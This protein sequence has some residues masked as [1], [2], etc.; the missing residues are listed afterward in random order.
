MIAGARGRAPRWLAVRCLLLWATAFVLAPDARSQDAATL[1]ARE[2]SLRDRLAHNAFRLPLVLESTDADGLLEGNIHAVVAQPFAAVAR[3]LQAA[4][5][6][7]DILIV[8]PNVKECRA[9]GAGASS[10]LGIALGRKFD[11]PLRDAYRLAFAYRVTASEPRY[12]GVRLIADSGP[13]GTSDY[14]ILVEATPI[15]A[16]RTF[17]HLSYSY[18]YGAAARLLMEGYLATI[19]RGKVGFS[20]L[21]RE[22]DGTPIYA[23]GARGVVERNTMRYYLAIE[24]YLGATATPAAGQAEKRLHDWFAAAER[25]PRQLHEMDLDE[26]LSIKRRE[27]VRQRAAAIAGN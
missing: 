13:L 27:L 3:A 1:L 26:Y 18:V 7:C 24:S 19:G 23:D 9:S 10:V 15:D 5:Q 16:Q 2:V 17:L 14:R 25:Y 6:W 21:G 4:G 11:Q 20:I 22:P 8:H 12:L